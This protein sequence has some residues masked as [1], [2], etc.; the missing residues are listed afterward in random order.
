MAGNIQPSDGGLAAALVD[1]AR[2]DGIDVGIVETHPG[3][4][5]LVD[6]H[7]TCSRGD[8][9]ISRDP[10]DGFVVLFG[11][12][13]HEWARG[14]TSDLREA[15]QA[16]QAW[17]AGVTLRE[18]AQRYP[19]MSYTGLA[20]AYEDGTAID[21]RWQEILA[22]PD[23]EPYRTLLLAVRADATLGGL[24]PSVSHRNFLRLDMGPWPRSDAEVHIIQL[25]EHF[26]VEA[27][28]D[29]TPRRA[30]TVEDAVA[31]AAA[32]VVA[33]RDPTKTTFTGEAS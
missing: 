13:G 27:S 17:R 3:D 11:G 21:Y 6:A 23:L 10:D 14:R 31:L 4:R 33:D 20:Q 22:D 5:A 24:A 29:M 16:A 32:L 15:A 7:L 8:I 18:L 26:Q 25:R 28:W 12:P 1:L 30:D 2:R 9:I 19:F